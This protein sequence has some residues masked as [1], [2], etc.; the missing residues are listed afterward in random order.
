MLYSNMN[1]VAVPNLLKIC[2]M[3]SW[4][5]MEGSTAAQA[6]T[7]PLNKERQFCH[8][9]TPECI[10]ASVAFSMVINCQQFVLGS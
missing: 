2:G 7:V 3:S 9:H 5:T 8:R 6:V 4:L 1:V 10:E